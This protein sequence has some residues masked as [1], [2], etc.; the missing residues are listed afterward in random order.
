[1][2]PVSPACVPHVSGL[3][4]ERGTNAAAI[5]RRDTGRPRVR[6]EKCETVFRKDARQN[7]KLEPAFDSIESGLYKAF[8]RRSGEVEAIE[9]HHFGPCRHEVF[10]KLLLRVRARV[11]FRDGPE[12]GVRTEDQ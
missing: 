8:P 2:V 7:K 10:H 12:L 1:M 5:W 6:P 9:A 11:D 4:C 3:P